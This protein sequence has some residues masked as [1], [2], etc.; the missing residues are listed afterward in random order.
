MISKPFWC[1]I[2]SD[3]DPTADET[4]TLIS[5]RKIE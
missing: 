3:N 5:L 1:K 4:H 2:A